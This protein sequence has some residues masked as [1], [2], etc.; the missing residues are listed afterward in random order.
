MLGYDIILA[1]KNI[2]FPYSGAYKKFSANWWH[3]ML[4][5]IFVIAVFLAGY[6]TWMSFL[7][8]EEVGYTSCDMLQKAMYSHNPS[9]VA[10][11]E[12]QIG[13]RQCLIDHQIHPLVDFGVGLFAAVVAF[14]LFQFLYYKAI[15][16]FVNDKEGKRDI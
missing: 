8:T 5:V 14:Y 9:P 7:Q 10:E 3:R 11:R 16:F 12:L 6:S 2:L 15:C 13:E 1:M 4:I